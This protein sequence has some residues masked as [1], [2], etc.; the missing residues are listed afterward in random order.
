MSKTY[1]MIGYVEDIT[2]R[3]SRYDAFDHNIQINTKSYRLFN[4]SDI[5]L[6][7]KGDLVKFNYTLT[8]Q[9]NKY[10]RICQAPT[11]RSIFI[12]SV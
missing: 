10:F 12:V 1:E 4:N 9:K 8:G 6:L 7:K 2:S 11:F 5:C 3:R